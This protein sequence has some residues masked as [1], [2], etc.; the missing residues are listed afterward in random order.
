MLLYKFFFF[1][2]LFQVTGE[3]IMD[4]LLE[5]TP[6]LYEMYAK[7]LY[8]DNFEQAVEDKGAADR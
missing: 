3:E 8:E 4:C 6:S 1:N 2:Y 7:D 5:G